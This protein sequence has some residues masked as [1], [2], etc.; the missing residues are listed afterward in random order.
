MATTTVDF[1]NE[2]LEYGLDSSGVHTTVPGNVVTDYDTHGTVT[3]LSVTLDGNDITGAL[4]STDG[5]IY[6]HTLSGLSPGSHTL[7]FMAQDE[8]GNQTTYS[9]SFLV[10]SGPAPPPVPTSGAWALLG[11]SLAFAA[12]IAYRVSRP[13]HR[14]R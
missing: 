4:T 11:P 6:R 13:K 8:A 10:T 7:S 5:V 9:Y 3:A 1:S 12:F 2:G 14:L